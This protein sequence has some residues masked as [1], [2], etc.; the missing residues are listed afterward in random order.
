[1][2]DEHRDDGMY[3]ENPY[4]P[5]E[6][7][8]RYVKRPRLFLGLSP[9]AWIHGLVETATP[10]YATLPRVRGTFL[11]F[12]MFCF[13]V[14]YCFFV[15]LTTRTFTCITSIARSLI[16]VQNHFSFLS[17]VTL[18]G[19]F[20]WKGSF[21]LSCSLAAQIVRERGIVVVARA[22]DATLNDQRMGG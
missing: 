20:Q 19:L 18:W 1:M 13:W 7:V 9:V 12:I 17:P 15:I 2:S 22:N 10:G 16:M 14:V 3:E 6:G 8:E 21:L 4:M 11:I 5:Y